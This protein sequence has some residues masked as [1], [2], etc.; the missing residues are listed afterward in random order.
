MKETSKK[1]SREK[2]PLIEKVITPLA[3]SVLIRLG[4]TAAGSATDASI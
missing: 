3:E 1:I 2:L 4:L